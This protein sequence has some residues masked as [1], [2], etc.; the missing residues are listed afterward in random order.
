MYKAKIE[1]AVADIKKLQP[2]LKFDALAF[3]GSSGAAIAFPAAV[4]LCIPIIYVRKKGEKSHGDEIETTLADFDDDI[5]YLIVDDFICE[6]GT[7]T[8]IYK[9]LSK[10]RKDGRDP[11][12]CVGIYQWSSRDARREDSYT[13]YTSQMADGVTL[14][15]FRAKA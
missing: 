3:S 10:K 8:R 7:V 2:K 6:G 15:L 14:K 4:E 12:T 13:I 5:K 1:K 11:L 9:K